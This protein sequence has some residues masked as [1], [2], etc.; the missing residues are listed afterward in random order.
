MRAIL[1]DNKWIWFDNI[2]VHEEEVLWKEFSVSDP[3]A[4]VDPSQLG[5]WDGIFR[6][7]NR[8]KKRMARP[9]LS[10]LR[11]VCSQYD[12]PLEILDKRD[13]WEYSVI[14]Q[15]LITEDFLPGIKMDDHQIRAIR[16]ACQAECGIINVPTGGGKCF[17]PGTPVMMADMSIKNVEDIVVGDYVMGDDSRPRRVLAA[18][19]G[20]GDLY[21]IVPKNGNAFIVSQDHIMSLMRIPDGESPMMDYGICDIR[22]EDYLRISKTKK[23][24][25]KIY[26]SD[27]VNGD[28]YRHLTISGDLEQIRSKKNP[29]VCGF[30]VDHI[31]KGD[32]YGFQIDGNGRFL[33]SDFTV[34]HNSEIISGICK[35]IDCPTVIVAD[36]R[37]VIDQLKARLELRQINPDIGLFY[38]GKRPS[39]Q[40]IIVGSIQSLQSP[41]APPELPDRKNFKSDEEYAKKAARWDSMYKAYK[42]RKKNAK[43]LQDCVKNAEMV[44]VDECDKAAGTQFKNFFRHWFSGRR[45]YGLSGTPFDPAKPV[46]N[47]TVQEHLGSVIAK[48]T[49]QKLV[50][51]GRIIT[52]DYIMIGVGPFD[53]IRESS[54]YDIARNEHMVE[55][56]SFHKIIASICKKYKGDGTLILVDREPLGHTLVDAIN[57]TGLTAHFIY[58]KTPKRRR[59]ELLRSFERREFDVLIGGKIINR[60]LDL[61][62]GCENLIIATGGKLQSEFEQK[63][64]R[65][66][67]RNKMGRSRVFDFFFRCNKH[68]YNHS[69]ARLQVMVNSNYNTSVVFPGGRIDGAQLI[70]RRFQLTKNY[71]QSNH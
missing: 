24:L 31:G 60:G 27:G 41:P 64:G 30:G 3:N 32:Y 29:L 2:T 55:S 38:A 4:Y 57:R 8:A 33:L 65:A 21:K 35:A 5:M 28:W 66:L 44:I 25:L 1:E 18:H 16:R 54:M 10:M 69:K 50:E 14:D 47:L 52:C 19:N 53:G 36:Q 51:I 7:Y 37:I 48:E 9:L 39:D 20:I 45:R 43:Y 56:P 11:S 22:I 12:L 15:E 71:F 42:T 67:R 68:L 58:G 34:V 6:K 23:H 61:S 70:Q 40:T 63:I 62:G 59:D 17:A 46:A 49:R 13:K 26:K